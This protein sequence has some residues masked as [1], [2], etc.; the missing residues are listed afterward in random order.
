MHDTRLNTYRDFQISHIVVLHNVAFFFSCCI[1]ITSSV[2]ECQ[3]DTISFHAEKSVYYWQCFYVAFSTW[4]SAAPENK[5]QAIKS[6]NQ[7]LN[8]STKRSNL[9]TLWQDGL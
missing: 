9:L 6:E 3:N 7:T 2:Y 4:S 8:P 1:L 5:T